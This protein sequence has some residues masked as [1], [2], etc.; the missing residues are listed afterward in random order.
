MTA[1]AEM[2]DQ[3][4]PVSAEAV[5]EPETT[6]PTKKRRRRG[7]GTTSRSG[8]SGNSKLDRELASIQ[9]AFAQLFASVMIPAS[10][11]PEPYASDCFIIATNGA[12]YMAP[13]L[14]E[15]CR[16]N[17]RLRDALLGL[18]E[19]SSYAGL[20]QAA[21]TIIIPI[22]YNHGQVPGMLAAP[23]MPKGMTIEVPRN[24]V[25]IRA[26]QNS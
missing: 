11:F 22:A 13:A 24:V 14:A 17:P 19:V 25:P 4:N 18:G 23:F 2:T 8:S 15:L 5:P 12:E 10:F 7:A 21:L 3:V 26:N 16:N 20:I 1:E 6:Q 9:A